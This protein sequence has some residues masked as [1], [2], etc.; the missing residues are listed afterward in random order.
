MALTASIPQTEHAGSGIYEV[1]EAARYIKASSAGNALYAVKSH[2]LYRWLRR[3]VVAGT[4]S[5]GVTRDVFLSFEDLISMRVIV[6]LRNAGVSWSSIDQA[7]RWLREKTGMQWPFA[8]EVLWTGQGEI[9]T[10]WSAGLVATGRHGQIALSLLQEHLLP[11]KDMTFS[12]TSQVAISWEPL[13]GIVLEPQIQ[14]GAPCIKG[15]RIPTRTL[16]GMVEAGDSKEWVAKAFGISQEAVQAA[17]D[18]ETRLQA[19]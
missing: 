9:F 13:H 8:T 7:Q 3:G 6:V 1:P 10:A 19:N 16:F 17:C 15:T 18:W 12:K 5:Q 11:I 4:K 2:N 14:F